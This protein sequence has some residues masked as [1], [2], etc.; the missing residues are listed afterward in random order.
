MLICSQLNRAPEAAIRLAVGAACHGIYVHN[1]LLD[2]E[3]RGFVFGRSAADEG[4]CWFGP[5]GNLVIVGPPDVGS[6]VEIAGA[7]ADRIQ[8]ARLPW[9][10][11]MGP[12][13]IVDALRDRCSGTPLVHRNQVYYLGVAGSI[14]RSLVR[15]DVRAAEPDDRDRIIQATLQLNHTD[16]LIEPR[17]VDRRWL[18]DT[19]SE[20]IAE[21]ST[22]VLGPVGRIDCKLDFGSVGPGGLVIEG[23]FTFPEARGRGLAAA[24]VATCIAAADTRVGLHVGEHNVP[25]R[26]AYERAGMQEVDRCRLLL[27]G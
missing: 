23:V 13:P 6:C 24:L 17:R 22:R 20:R 15:D 2:G 14:D 21:R 9:R 16:L 27:L 8:R 7:V 3:R 26:R 4:L 5:R 11:A 18:H 10:I 19:V 25:A 1:A 12:R